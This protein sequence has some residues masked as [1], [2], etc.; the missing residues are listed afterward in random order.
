MI[1]FIQ[2]GENGPIKIG[3]SDNVQERFKQLQTACP[4]ELKLLW[5]YSGEEYC[6]K[7]IHDKF[8]HEKVRGEWFHPSRTL[9]IFIK[10]N[11]FN[12]YEFDMI[13]NDRE[14][15]GVYENFGSGIEVSGDGFILRKKNDKISIEP[16]GPW[17]L[18]VEV[19]NP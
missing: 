9:Y 5:M 15:I 4:Y 16:D 17:K 14:Y 18:N 10:N 7:D 11:L 19:I 1:Y 12:S 8:K 2:C 13:N 3:Q 6:E